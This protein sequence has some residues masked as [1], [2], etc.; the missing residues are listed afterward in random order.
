MALLIS[1]ALV[2][3]VD[4][5]S[6]KALT[7]ALLYVGEDGVIKAIKQV[8]L[9]EAG[10]VDAFLKEVGHS[11]E[12]ER[13]DLARG[14]FLIPGFI[15][16]HTVRVLHHRTRAMWLNPWITPELIISKKT[17]IACSTISQYWSRATVRALGLA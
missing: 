16:T 3:P 13:L 12:L 10:D 8:E 4:Q 2:S 5:R 15:D 1:G 9:A 17:T 14:E 7:N 6:Y 11:G